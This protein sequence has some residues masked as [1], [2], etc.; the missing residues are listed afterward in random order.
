M[1]YDAM[2]TPSIIECICKV[3]QQCGGK[4]CKVRHY[5]QL[6]LASVRFINNL[7]LRETRFGY[8]EVDLL[9]RLER[10]RDKRSR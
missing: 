1:S 7:G 3:V 8:G 5:P 10:W 2:D 9:N 4:Q 6:G